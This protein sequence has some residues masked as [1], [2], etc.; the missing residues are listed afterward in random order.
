MRFY[1]CV[2]LL[3]LMCMGI[4]LNVLR[5][6]CDLAESQSA[7]YYEMACTLSDIVRYSIDH[8]DIVAEEL[9]KSLHDEIDAYNVSFSAE[10]L[11]TLYWQY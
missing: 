5:T 6:K 10:E 9:Y 2:S 11:D 7:K 3:V 4:E 8:G 1:V